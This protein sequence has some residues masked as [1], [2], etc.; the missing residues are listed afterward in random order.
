VRDIVEKHLKYQITSDIFDELNPG[1][2]VAMKASEGVHV[3]CEY[4]LSWLDEAVLSPEDV[5]SDIGDD[6]ISDD[7]AN[8][9]LI[10][11]R[12]V[13]A[14]FCG[15]SASA[16]YVDGSTSPA[17]EFLPKLFSGQ[18]MELVIRD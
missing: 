8:D 10:P 2:D 16:A 5:I 3:A 18:S 15:S 14:T 6:I 4:Q 17:S 13:H 1:V 12:N 11:C 7:F 9:L